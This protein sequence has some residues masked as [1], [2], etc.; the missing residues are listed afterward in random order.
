MNTPPVRI[1][2]RPGTPAPGRR[3]HR[4]S[5][6]TRLALLAAGMIA[7]AVAAAALVAYQ[8]SAIV[9]SQAQEQATSKL[10]QQARDYLVQVNDSIAQ[11][12]DLVLDR[13]VRDVNAV[14][15]L[16]ADLYASE[17]RAANAATASL[18]GA[19]SQK[20]QTGPEGQRLNGA[21]DI[22]SLFIPNT[23]PFDAQTRSDVDIT[24]PLAPVLRA[25]QQN[26]PNAAA[27]YLGTARNLTRYYPNIELG[28]LVPADFAVTGRPW[29]TSAV[30]G[31]QAAASGEQSERRPIWSPAYQDATGLG[32]VTTVAVPVFDQAG[33]VTGVVGLDVTLDE[34]NRSISSSRFYESGYSFLIDQQGRPLL[35][36]AA[37]YADI[38]GPDAPELEAQ[39]LLDL[40]LEAAAAGTGFAAVLYRMKRGE[41][42]FASLQANS[43]TQGQGDD[44]LVAFSP[45]PSTGWSL[46]SVARADEVMQEVANLENE[47]TRVSQELAFTRGLPVLAIVALLLVGLTLLWTDRIVTPLR[48]LAQ[49]AETLTPQ[50]TGGEAPAGQDPAAG[51]EAGAADPFDAVT[52]YLPGKDGSANDEIGQLG[53]A[54]ATMAGQL[55]ERF[56]LQQQR[57]DERTHQ[58]EMRSLQIQTASEIAR[59]ISGAS[60]L[61]DL[62]Q[63]A[64]DLVSERF[65]YYNTGIF[66]VDES[67]EYA[68]L[69]AASGDLGLRLLNENVRLRVGFQGIVGYVTRYGQARLAHDVASD[70]AYHADPLLPD[71]RSE[72]ALPLRKAAFSGPAVGAGRPVQS[73]GFAAGPVPLAAQM[74]VIGALDVQSTEAGAFDQNDI[75]ILQILADQLAIAIENFRLVARLQTALEESSQLYQEQVRRLWSET[76]SGAAGYLYNQLEVVPL[77]QLAPVN[78]A[79]PTNHAAPAE[80]GTGT[81]QQAAPANAGAV[82]TVSV[83]LR[84]HDQVIGQIRIESDDP[85]HRWSEDEQAVI[86]AAAIQASLSLE[87][88]R[89]LEATRRQALRQQITGEITSRM[90]ASLDI[91]SVLQTGLR[92]MVERLGLARIEVQLGGSEERLAEEKAGGAGSTGGADGP[93]GAAGDPLDGQIEEREQA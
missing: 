48:R 90:R 49:A 93:G 79:A 24:E 1:D 63:R 41:S 89:L 72:V 32:L 15:A 22:T 9:T 55:S 43:G 27:I 18:P 76:R 10:R 83:P 13:A 31:N 85:D 53:L 39:E 30:E 78:Q 51:G 42:G 40:D 57:V 77:H 84:I 37:A 58:L 65:G 88:A 73:Q 47:L 86:E 16:V 81:A 19:A 14:A 91:E 20:L 4:R 87:N 66:L 82:A 61:D 46:A 74:N 70:P 25:I 12:N 68:H 44:L 33:Q 21:E 59:D 45:L 92:E 71:T 7:L 80:P 23:Q 29:Y 60:N 36:S 75:V 54:L 28:K 50:I 26:N 67:G 56:A 5:L 62:L 17:T 64:V 6:R 2:L 8:I 52:G 69:K 3:V 38:A 35:L 11:Q 34:I